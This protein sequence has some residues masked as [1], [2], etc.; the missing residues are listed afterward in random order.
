MGIKRLKKN[1]MQSAM[2][3]NIVLKSDIESTSS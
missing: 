1:Q 2:I 3:I